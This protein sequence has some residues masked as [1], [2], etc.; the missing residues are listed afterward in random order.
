MHFI[1]ENLTQ[2]YLRTQRFMYPASG[3]KMLCPRIED[4][5][6]LGLFGFRDYTGIPRPT[7]LVV[8]LT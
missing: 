6:L 4:G 3:R 1:L 7:C 2:T 5:Q 8:Y